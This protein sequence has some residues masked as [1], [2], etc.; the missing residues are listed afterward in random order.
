[1]VITISNPSRSSNSSRSSSKRIRRRWSAVKVSVKSVSVIGRETTYTGSPATTRGRPRDQADPR[2]TVMTSV[3]SGASRMPTRRRRNTWD[4]T[5]IPWWTV[6]RVWTICAITWTLPLAVTRGR[7]GMPSPGW[8]RVGCSP[9]T[10]PARPIGVPPSARWTLI[11]VSFRVQ[12]R[13]AKLIRGSCELGLIK[14]ITARLMQIASKIHFIVIVRKK[15]RE[16]ARVELVG[17]RSPNVESL[18]RKICQIFGSDLN[19]K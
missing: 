7:P 3:T 14:P 18:K 9:F 15:N 4:S 6:L 10:D 8:S 11:K 12:W 17:W 13:L 19:I 16:R 5:V 1:M 2:E